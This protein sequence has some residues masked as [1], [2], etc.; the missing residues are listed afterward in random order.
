MKLIQYYKLILK[1]NKQY[2]YDGNPIIYMNLTITNKYLI[3]MK[4]LTNIMTK[5]NSIMAELGTAAAYA[6]RH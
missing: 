4:R 3:T 5:I 2:E 6:I 1:S